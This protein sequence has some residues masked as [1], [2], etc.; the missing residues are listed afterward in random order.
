MSILWEIFFKFANFRLAYIN[1]SQKPNTEGD[2]IYGE[3]KRR[4]FEICKSFQPLNKYK[5][6]S[7]YE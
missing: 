6:E 3:F 1:R 4:K 5:G 2:E 7:I